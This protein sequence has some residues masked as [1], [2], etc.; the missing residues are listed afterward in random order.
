MH[1][2]VVP[3][4]AG[5]PGA[6]LA[7][8]PSAL[9]FP[10]IDH[11]R[12]LRAL[13]RLAGTQSNVPVPLYSMNGPSAIVGYNMPTGVYLPVAD[14]IASGELPAPFVASPPAASVFVVSARR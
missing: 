9:D 7:C 5:G 8:V 3:V 1:T 6:S 11:G 12:A 14:A 4:V 13:K 10:Q 2:Q